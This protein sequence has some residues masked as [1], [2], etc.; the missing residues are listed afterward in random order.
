MI[1]RMCGT[2][3]EMGGK[4]LGELRE[5][6]RSPDDP[7]ALRDRLEEDGYLLLRGLHSRDRVLAARRRILEAMDAAGR[8]DRTRPLMEGAVADPPLEGEP[9]DA[10]G[11]T[12]S[13]EMLGLVESPEI[14][15]FF[16]GILGGEVCTFDYK[17][18]RVVPPGTNTAAHYDVVYMGL[19]T[20]DLFTC[21]TPIGDVTPEMG[22]LAV[23][24]GSHRIEK[25]RETY[26]RMDVD[27]DRI[28]GLFSKDPL[29]MVDRY[30]GRWLTTG[31]APGDALIFGMYTM[32]AS[33]DN[34]SDRFR[35][36]ADTRYQLASEPVDGRFMGGEPFIR[37]TPVH[38]IEEM[39]EKW[40]V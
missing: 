22:S 38:T 31:F 5:T 34:I 40:G 6:R 17:W 9:Y 35:L 14:I 24:A 21:W 16:E 12:R 26:G 3:M 8:L 30:G 39:R 25:I 23:L 20:R 37:E 27:R 32:H 4:Y 10:R 33:L 7:G 28:E 15:G 36:C 18:V 13:V 2:E 11:V 29:E 19:G 1:L